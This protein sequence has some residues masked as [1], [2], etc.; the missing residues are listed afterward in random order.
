M[1]TVSEEDTKKKV[2][3]TVSHDANPDARKLADNHYSRKTKGA[4]FFCGPGEKL[5]LITPDKETL[6]SLGSLVF[7]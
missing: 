7:S 2:I 6:F 5:V 4:T 1:A 3:W